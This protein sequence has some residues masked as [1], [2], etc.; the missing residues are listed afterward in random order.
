M[1]LLGVLAHHWRP[2]K[3]SPLSDAAKAHIYSPDQ[4]DCLLFHYEFTGRIKLNQVICQLTAEGGAI[5]YVEDDFYPEIDEDIYHQCVVQLSQIQRRE[6]WLEISRKENGA[7]SSRGRSMERQH[8]LM[9]TSFIICGAFYIISSAFPI[10]CGA[11]VVICGTFVIICGAFVI[12]CG[13]FVIICGPFVIICS[14]FIF[15]CSTFVVVCGGFF[16]V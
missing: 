10:I 14:A 9:S 15:I 2:K 6:S 4:E 8:C 3:T 1:L 12:I 13:A 11:F 16:I 5:S 7:S